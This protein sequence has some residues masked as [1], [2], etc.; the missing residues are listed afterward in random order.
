MLSRRL[1]S[2]MSAVALN[3]IPT[4]TQL[5]QRGDLTPVANPLR[6]ASPNFN[7][8]VSVYRGDI[9]RLHVGAIVNAANESLLGGGG[10]DGAIHRAAGPELVNECYTLDGCD[11]GDAK[12]TKGYQLPADRVI[13]AVGPVYRQLGRERAEAALRG[14]YR[15]SLELAVEN[16]CRSVAFSAISTGIYGYPSL[17]A[18][19]VAC[20]TT[21]EFLE[22]KDGESLRRVI[23][24]TFETKDVVAYKEA[25]P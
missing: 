22:G 21:R 9:T 23:F 2:T 3:E 19:R 6:P 1:L 7:D 17:D 5:Y 16:D 8:R 25:V 11:T 12:I 18:A 24:V 20:E 4:L 14:C 13:H 10:V 15:R